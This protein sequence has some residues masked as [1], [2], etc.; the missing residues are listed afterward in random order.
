MIYLIT[1]FIL[2]PPQ[3]TTEEKIKEAAVETTETVVEKTADA[4]EI[5]SKK[6]S[7]LLDT[8]KEKVNKANE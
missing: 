4:A 8:I 3:K 7:G 1:S 6:A 5:V 2:F